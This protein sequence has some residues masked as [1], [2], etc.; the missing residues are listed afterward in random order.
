[1]TDEQET[2]TTIYGWSSFGFFCLFCL[3]IIG[4]WAYSFYH[5]FRGSYVPVGDDQGQNFSELEAVSIYVPQGTS[6]FVLFSLSLKVEERSIL[7]LMLLS[8]FPTHNSCFN[9]KMCSCVSVE[10]PVFSYPLLACTVDDM[11]KDMLDWTDPEHPHAF[12]DLTKDAQSLI[13]GSDISE[14]VVFSQ[15]GHWPPE[16]KKTQ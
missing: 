11:D 10:S 15:V 4:T 16:T 5:Y 13:R 14:K 2:V 9:F 12:Y 1:M 7:C 3:I 6:L 8:H